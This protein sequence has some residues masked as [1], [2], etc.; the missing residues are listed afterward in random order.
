MHHQHGIGKGWCF[1]SCTHRTMDAEPYTHTLKVEAAAWLDD[2]SFVCDQCPGKDEHV[3]NEVHALL[4][5]LDHR[6]CELRK[7]FSFLFTLFSRTFQ[8]P[9]P[10]CCGRSTTKIV[11]NLLSQQNTRLF[12]WGSGGNRS[13]HHQ[14]GLVLLQIRSMSRLIRMISVVHLME[15]KGLSQLPRIQPS[16]EL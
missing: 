15:R 8:R 12:K 14:P 5:C 4:N 10:F 3:Q 2:G 1:V 16:Q 11:H 9:T 6:I 13:A 7:Q